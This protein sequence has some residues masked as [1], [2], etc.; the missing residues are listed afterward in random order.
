MKKLSI[1]VPSTHTRR[2]GFMVRSMDMLFGQWERLSEDDQDRVEIL[3]FV[4][5]KSIMLGAKRNHMVDSA[6]GEYISFVDDDDRI[7]PDYISTLLDAIDNGGNPDVITFVVSVSL[8]GGSPKNCYYS[9]EF[10]E[11]F[12]THDAY[13]RLP[14]HICCVKKELAL[15][16]PFPSV[17]KGE[18]AAYAK[19]LKTHLKTE[20]KLD[21]TLYHYDYSD[22]STETQQKA[23]SRTRVRP[24]P[25]VADVVIV[26]K[27]TDYGM[28]KMTQIAIDTCIS[29][30]NGLPVNVIVIEQI[31]GVEYKNATTVL[32]ES[33][34][35]YNAMLNRGAFKGNA[36][37]IVF[38]NND[39]EFTDGWL[40]ALAG[41]GYPLVSTHNPRDPRQQNI[42][43]V[44]Y[45]QTNGRHLSGWCF[46]MDRSLWLTIGGLDE[47]FTG[48]FCD[49]A[50]IHQALQVGIT[51]AVVRDSVVFHKVSATIVTLPDEERRALYWGKLERFN[52][53]YGQEKFIDHPDF[54][55]WK[56]EQEDSSS[57]N[58]KESA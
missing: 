4:D 49:D 9:K 31:P 17:I 13:F 52:E 16:V 6:S 37:L 1:L 51:P 56:N 34:F 10:Y 8:N 18:D 7:S 45:G 20:V 58:Y 3:Y 46:A 26:S 33:P 36:P 30:A 27:A 2:S 48:W 29:G 32:D 47:E 53:K 21:K 41:S 5:N 28:Q 44:E 22:E 35:A 54:L 38:S 24:I 39:V 25:P 14:N 40:H 15:K 50:V 55:A 19:L 57:D 43:K 11:D 42:E 23:V 12:N